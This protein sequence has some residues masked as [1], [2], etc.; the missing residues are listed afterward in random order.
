MKMFGFGGEEKK[1]IKN[2][3]KGVLNKTALNLNTSNYQHK[4]IHT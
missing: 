3:D 1:V 4:Y 2:T